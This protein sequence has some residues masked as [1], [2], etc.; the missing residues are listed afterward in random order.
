[1]L[2]WF[3]SLALAGAA[4][5]ADDAPATP[6]A[7]TSPST[8]APSTPPSE[9]PPAPAAPPADAPSADAPSADAVASNARR[10]WIFVDR[11]KEAGGVVESEDDVTIVIREPGGKISSFAKGRI[12]AVVT[13]AEPPEGGQEGIIHL[14]DGRELRAWIHADD[15]DGVEYEIAGI[16]NRMPRDAVSMVSLEPDFDERYRRFRESIKPNEV[17]KRLTFAQWLASE[18]RF[19]LAAEEL[20]AITREFDLPEA[21]S[22]LRQVEAQLALEAASKG[23]RPGDS[24]DA[25]RGGDAR[26]R[27]GSEARRAGPVDL[28][29]LLPSRIL[30][31]DDV[32]VLRV[33]EV[34]LEKPPRM[35]IPPDVIRDLI[36]KYGSSS[37][38]PTGTEERNRMFSWEPVRI[39]KLMFDLKARDLYP[40]VRV[41]S[42]P[43]SLNLFRTRVHDAWLIP[44]CAT[45]QCHGGIDSG[46]FFLHRRNAKDER[47]RATNLLILLRSRLDHPLVDFEDP[48]SSLIIQHA[49]PRDEARYPHPEV[50]GW[51]P[52]FTGTARALKGQAMQ[53]IRAMYRPR[54]EYPIDYEPP[55]LDAIDRAPAE[56]DSSGAER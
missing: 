21:R 3:V 50:K 25:P 34:D 19:E 47:V 11:Y 51:K 18:K 43:W 17:D 38:V 39:L 14:R 7:E 49:L 16:R 22:L 2:D 54:P 20:R 13:L 29:D 42:E 31:H 33:Y 6:P 5:V 8:D 10:V 27:T 44:N 23:G 12:I 35:E 4:P 36:T 28:R 32:N 55:R 26:R 15:F 40:R 37:L 9:T 30:S 52:V 41:L 46:R 24:G 1:M 53:W 56:D 45:S 48:E